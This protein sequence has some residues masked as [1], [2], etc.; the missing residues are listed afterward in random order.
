MAHCYD[1]ILRLPKFAS[2]FRDIEFVIFDLALPIDEHFLVNFLHVFVL[3]E[4]SLFN[5]DKY[6]YRCLS[7]YNSVVW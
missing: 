3:Y 4:E 5:Q 1:K 6:I 2:A 7:I